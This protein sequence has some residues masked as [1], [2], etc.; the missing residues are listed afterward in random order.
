MMMPARPAA[1]PRL[2]VTTI[3]VPSTAMARPFSCGD[4]PLPAAWPAA[5]SYGCLQVPQSGN[6]RSAPGRRASP[7]S[8]R[9]ENPQADPASGANRARRPGF[10]CQAAARLVRS[11]TAGPSAAAA[12]A[13]TPS[14]GVGRR[15]RREQ[16]SRSRT[17]PACQSST[18]AIG[19]S[20]VDHQEQQADGFAAGP[21]RHQVGDQRHGG[22][23]VPGRSSCR[24]IEHGHHGWQPG[25]H[26]VISQGRRARQR[27]PAC[28]KITSI[29]TESQIQSDRTRRSRGSANGSNPHRSSP[30]PRPSWP[31][32]GPRHHGQVD[33]ARNS[34]TR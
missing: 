23:A 22:Q 31:A 24:R 18:M 4:S 12:R 2:H 20:Q 15:V 3:T 5:G 9:K 29:G 13:M 1:G 14:T 30:V 34:S 28:R 10:S 16:P 11:I 25:P 19:G 27:S 21:R 32:T 7:D 17:S 26:G 6:T 33:A 8:R